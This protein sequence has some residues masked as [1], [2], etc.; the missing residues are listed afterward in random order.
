MVSAVG[1]L[2]CWT[3]LYIAPVQV[4]DTDTADVAALDWRPTTR[5]QT[6]PAV[7]QHGCRPVP[8][9][10]QQDLHQKSRIGNA[11]VDACVYRVVI[12]EWKLPSAAGAIFYSKANV[13]KRLGKMDILRIENIPSRHVDSAFIVFFYIA[14]KKEAYE[15][16]F[17]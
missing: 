13:A 16:D 12:S 4:C 7:S 17:K 8:D 5:H 1:V 2:V 14:T 15:C 6:R 9:G 11:I 10:P 3:T